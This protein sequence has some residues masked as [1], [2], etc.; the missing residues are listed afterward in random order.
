MTGTVTKGAAF[1]QDFD[2]YDGVS[3]AS[4]RIDSTGGTVTGLKVGNTVDV[5]AV[6]GDG[7]NRTD[8]TLQAAMNAVGSTKPVAFELDPSEWAIFNDLTLTS[9]ITL[10]VPPGASFNVASGKTLTI[11]GDLNAGLYKVFSG[12]GTVVGPA[13]AIAIYPHWWDINGLGG[14]DDGAAL[15]AA[16]AAATSGQTVYHPAGTYLTGTQLVILDDA[17]YVFTKGATLTRAASLVTPVIYGQDKSNFLIEYP[18]IDG[19]KSAGGAAGNGMGIRIDGCT[20]WDIIGARIS[21]CLTDGIY[22]SKGA[23]SVP[24]SDFSIK[25]CESESNDRHGIAVVSGHNF[26]IDDNSV[27]DNVY[28]GIDV[29][30]NSGNVGHTFKIRGNTCNDNGQSGHAPTSI[31]G[32]LVTLR[33]AA[34]EADRRD[35]IVS[36]NICNGNLADGAADGSGIWI[37]DAS[38]VSLVDNHCSD[39]SDDGIR[40]DRST[41]L[42][43]DTT[44]LTVTGNVCDDNGADGITVS[45]G[46]ASDLLN[47]AVIVGNVARGNTGFGFEGGANIRAGMVGPNVW[48]NNAGGETTFNS[49]GNWGKTEDRTELTD[50]FNATIESRSALSVFQQRDLAAGQTDLDLEIPGLLDWLDQPMVRAGSVVGLA[51]RFSAAIP[52]GE[53]ATAKIKKNGAATALTVVVAAG[54]QSGEVTADFSEYTYAAGDRIGVVVDTSNNGSWA[55]TIDI[56]ATVETVAFA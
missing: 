1:R 49:F 32:I 35:I 28:D 15:A 27:H 6:Y 47:G 9:N 25:D 36:G 24:S 17:R 7:T 38:R 8:A 16:W 4:S 19:N 26:E 55:T 42:G 37:R 2:L 31:A 3:T 33:N 46:G 50:G 48:Q 44:S 14:A 54:S 34:A 56:I 51:V 20:D 12:S 21:N 53:T 30:L 13:R 45:G 11:N 29:E 40:V 10:F 41:V 52:A 18:V 22:V 43:A 23:T 39:N 5:L